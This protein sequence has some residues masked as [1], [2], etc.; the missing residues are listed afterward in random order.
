MPRSTSR[1]RRRSVFGQDLTG[2]GVFCTFCAI[3]SGIGPESTSMV[4]ARKSRSERFVCQ[5]LEL[6]LLSRPSAPK[7]RDLCI[8]P[9]GAHF[10]S[11]RT[12][13][14]SEFLAPDSGPIFD[15][16]CRRAESA[17]MREMRRKA[18]ECRLPRAFLLP[19][20][21]VFFVVNVVQKPVISRD[22]CWKTP[23][24]SRGFLSG[25]V[26]GGGADVVSRRPARRLGGGGGGLLRPRN[27]IFVLSA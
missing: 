19:A 26:T 4:G 27:T 16:C 17:E 11:A 3:L 21:S 23:P 13:K 8:F 12:L 15:P 20:R 5:K 25:R 2:N 10:L 22:R 9:R 18:Q 7:G 6:P 14:T 24:T 1:F